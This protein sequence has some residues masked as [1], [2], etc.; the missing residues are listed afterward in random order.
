MSGLSM[1]KCEACRGDAPRATATE[2]EQYMRDIS[3][4]WKL[5]EDGG[6]QKLRRVFKFKNFV[7]ALAFADRVGE[8]AENA[9]HHPDLLVQWGRTTVTW[10]SH[11]LGGLHR[12]DFIMAARS[13]SL[14]ER[15]GA[16]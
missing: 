1:E 6:V 13:D 3:P 11:K 9:G 5:V 16:E 15:G 14:F 4:D 2:I 7:Q 12:N 8:S 10:Y